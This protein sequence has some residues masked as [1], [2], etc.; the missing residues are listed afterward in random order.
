MSIS[1]ESS[2]VGVGTI[3]VLVSGGKARSFPS[4][5]TAQ[6]VLRECGSAGPEVFAALVNGVP[7]DLAFTLAENV[8]L[9]PISFS[10]P[11]G[12]EIYRHSSTHI[13]AQAVKDVFP[14]ANV[15]IGPAIDEGFFYDFAFERSFTPEDLEK[16]E[17]R[18]HEIMKA[19]L[20]IKRLEMSKEEAIKI[21]EN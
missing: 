1:T 13:M 5:V 21:F 16:I 20:P 15:T 6:E 18:A 8:S 3:E 19:D 4:G 12:K 9:E 10:S 11:D 2:N 17:L 14:S 7:V